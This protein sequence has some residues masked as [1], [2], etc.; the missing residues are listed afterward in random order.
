M[1]I[2]ANQRY[3][4]NDEQSREED[5]ARSKPLPKELGVESAA[6]STDL[7]FRAAVVFWPLL[8]NERG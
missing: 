6:A 8:E 5:R 7:R 2:I 1:M 3:R 4:K